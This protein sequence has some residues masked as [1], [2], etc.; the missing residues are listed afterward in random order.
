MQHLSQNSW[1]N[2][3]A[4][5]S[6]FQRNYS[7]HQVLAFATAKWFAHPMVVAFNIGF[8]TS[9]IVA[10]VVAAGSSEKVKVLCR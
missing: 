2:I 3:A 4:I 5:D 6:C 8:V 10:M 9:K 7:C 1:S